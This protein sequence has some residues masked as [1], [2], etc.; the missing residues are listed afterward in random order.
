MN[1]DLH[2]IINADDLKNSPF[3]VPDSY[4]DSLESRLLANAGI[5]QRKKE[6][7]SWTARIIAMR[8]ARWA[9]ACACVLA[10]VG[11]VYLVT[12]NTN[13]DMRAQTDNGKTLEY[14]ADYSAEDA[15]N[16]AADYTMLDSHDM[17]MMLAEE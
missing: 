2:D 10:L 9:V 6:K 13:D 16:Q 1:K 15:F 12:T 4:F 11:T 17:Y 8:P 7:G 14:N 5:E 3:K